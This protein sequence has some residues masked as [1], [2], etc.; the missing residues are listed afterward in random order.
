MFDLEGYKVLVTA[1]TR[2]IGFGI[3]KVLLM[4]G[5][6]VVINGRSSESVRKAVEELKKYG[7]AHGIVADI[8]KHED[9]KRL[10]EEA[11]GFLGE[12]DALVYVTGPPKPGFFEELSLDDWDYGVKLLIMSAIWLTQYSLPH[13]KKSNNSSIVYSTSVAVKEPIPNIALSN[14]LRLSIH[15]LVKTLSRE[16]AK[17]GIRVNAV[18]PGYMMTSRV[19]QLIKD[20][21][22]REGRSEEEIL[23]ELVREV[24]LGRIGKPEEVGYLV[25]F[26]ISKYASY[27]TGASIPIDGGLLKSVL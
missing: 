1:S 27:I 23:K 11:V 22:S 14:V 7:K 15:G 24:P 2:G 18:L 19:K 21:A 9:A 10:V 26:L 13:L 3:A 20:K 8:T 16:L 6:S 12:L 5:A 25:A 4:N 17:Y